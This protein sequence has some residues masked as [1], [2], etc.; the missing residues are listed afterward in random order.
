MKLFALSDTHLCTTN[1]EKDMGVFGELWQNHTLKIKSRWESVVG[2]DDIV[3]IAGDICWA[4]KFDDGLEELRFLAD[5]PGEKVFIKGNHDYWWQS[6]KKVRSLAPSRMHF[7]Q[8]D[9]A[10]FDS[11]GIGGSRLWNFDFVKWPCVIRNI[12]LDEEKEG[13]ETIEQDADWLEKIQKREINRLDASLSKI[14]SPFRVAM[15]HFPPI[16]EN[17]NSNEITDLMT[18]NNI[19]ICVYGHLH[20]VSGKPKGTDC[21]I[22]KTRYVLTSADFLNFY[23]HHLITL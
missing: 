16:D 7:I 2:E 11:F 18:R 21:V 5:L 1:P 20:S 8:N 13:K 22:D 19:D 9:A 15:V 23:P 4:M 3:L 14:S 12:E 6:I 17:G 10:A